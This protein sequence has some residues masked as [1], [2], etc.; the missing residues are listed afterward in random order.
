ML[1]STGT[2]K[3]PVHRKRG[4][5]RSLFLS[6]GM[7]GNIYSTALIGLWTEP[8]SF[9][10]GVTR[11]NGPN[12]LLAKLHEVESCSTF[13]ETSLAAKH[14]K[15]SWHQLC[16]TL[17]LFLWLLLLWSC[18]QYVVVYVMWVRLPQTHHANCCFQNIT[19]SFLL[20]IDILYVLLFLF[21][22]RN[23]WNSPKRT[24]P[25]SRRVQNSWCTMVE[26]LGPLVDFVCVLFY[27]FLKW[28]EV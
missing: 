14:V 19:K 28:A 18:R 23:R 16:Y 24:C 3:L 6:L 7:T 10:R 1:T 15:V 11:C 26:V 20:G 21:R 25:E 2:G 13:R 17:Q 12:C 22:N 4:I 5:F 8:D 27:R 9:T